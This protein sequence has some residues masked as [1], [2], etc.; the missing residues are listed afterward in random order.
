M[1]RILLYLSISFIPL[2]VFSQVNWVSQI[3]V[4]QAMAIDEQKLI[5]MDFAA[6]WCQPCKKMES[7]LWTSEEMKAISNN[8]VF[9]RIDIDI[10]TVTA[11]RYGINSIPCVIIT[12]IAGDELWRMVGYRGN[13]KDY[14]DVF[15]QAPTNV[16]DLNTNLLPSLRNEETIENQFELGKIY[17]VLGEK[18]K[19]DELK[20][21]FLELSSTYFKQVQKKDGE[22]AKEAELRS[23]LNY[24]YLGKSKKALSKLQKFPD[25]YFS[26]ELSEL[27]N[28]INTLC[29]D[30]P[31]N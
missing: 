1:K 4:A 27:R 22:Q 15:E 24:V 29:L 19:Q 12:N 20:K 3:E 14:L 11:A 10:N 6:S 17:Q 2:S 23:L 9:L 21:T 8:F 18:Q 13:T 26:E 7:A 5:I 30:S 16:A 25:D 31:E 28:T